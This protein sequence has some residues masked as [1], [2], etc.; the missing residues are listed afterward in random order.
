MIGSDDFHL[1]LLAL[2]FSDL[3]LENGGESLSNGPLMSLFV[4]DLL[5]DH[6]RVK[7]FDGHE[8]GVRNELGNLAGG[9]H[10]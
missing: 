6:F 9:E 4:L 5:P 10:V 7:L 1:L 2:L 3:L 8:S